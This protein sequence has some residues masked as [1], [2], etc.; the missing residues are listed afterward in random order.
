MCRSRYV[1][2]IFYVTGSKVDL[3]FGT[4]SLRGGLLSRQVQQFGQIF[5]FLKKYSVHDAWSFL[6]E[7]FEKGINRRKAF[8]GRKLVE[9][10]LRLTLPGPRMFFKQLLISNS[11]K[12]F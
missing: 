2:C 8:A 4:N 1:T 7:S 10:S 6:V 3:L 12:K 11:R 5:C 9:R